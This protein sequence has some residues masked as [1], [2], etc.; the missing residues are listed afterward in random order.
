VEQISPSVDERKTLVNHL[1]VTVI[2]EREA[3]PE[4]Y[5]KGRVSFSVAAT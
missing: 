4:V 5:P 1:G 2:T 3:I